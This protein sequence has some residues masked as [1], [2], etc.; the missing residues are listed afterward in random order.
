MEHDLKKYN[1]PVVIIGAGLAGAVLAERFAGSGAKVL[2]IEKRDHVGGNCYD[3]VDEAGITVQ[4]YGPHIFHTNN[5]KV[6]EYISRFT[7]W[8]PYKHVVLARYKGKTYTLPVNLITIRELS[9][10]NKAEE[11]SQKLLNA[12]GAGVKIQISELLKSTDKSLTELAKKIYEVIYK[13]YS[14]KQW[15]TSLDKLDMK[16]SARVP[17]W[18][19]EDNR[20]FKD[21]YQ[22]IPV[23]GYTQII[24][25][26]LNNPNID[27]ILNTDYYNIKEEISCDKLF[28]SGEVDAFFN[29]EHGS[30]RYRSLKYEIE[31]LNKEYYQDAAVV[32][33]TD[34]TPFTRITEFKHF[35]FLKSWQ[36][37]I[38]KEYPEEYD[39]KMNIPSYPFLDSENNAKYKKYLSMAENNKNVILVGRLAEFKYYNMDGVI[40]R[41]LEVYENH[42][43]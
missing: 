15:G 37:T 43:L 38:M 5:E 29:Y 30:L 7:E 19:D 2:V 20:Y 17:I 8:L 9:A 35:N 10:K 21:K 33:Y 39:P 18:T 32:N 40:E 27:I 41:A 14:L 13:D 16:V 28:F 6:W 34:K 26:M 42:K 36:T 24:K 3:Y 11:I 25:N 31:T 1:S 22:G 12:Y 23:K 4:K